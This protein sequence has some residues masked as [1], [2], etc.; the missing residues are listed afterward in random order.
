MASY[1]GVLSNFGLT[2]SQSQTRSVADTLLQSID[3]AVAVEEMGADGAYFSSPSL[4]PPACFA[5][6]TAGGRRR[7]DSRRATTPAFVSASR[8]QRT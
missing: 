5:F 6:P 1:P 3:L 7:E 8:W 4:R 2:S